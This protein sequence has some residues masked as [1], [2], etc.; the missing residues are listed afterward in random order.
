MERRDRREGAETAGK[1]VLFVSALN[2]GRK[3]T[4]AS[5][6]GGLGVFSAVSALAATLAFASPY[7]HAPAKQTVQEA[8]AK[9]A[10]CMSCHTATDRATMHQNPGVVLG[11]T[12]CHG[13]DAKVLRPQG[14][15]R[16]DS[17]Y[18]ATLRR[19]HVLPRDERAW[20]WP[21]SATPERTFTLLNR[22]SP[23]FVRAS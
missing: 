18:L 11:C 16:E 8:E 22:E 5:F 19:A 2:E 15:K 12:D 10:G 20:R 23:E 17:A 6:L 1:G 13:G 21:S 4:L 3:H 9:S 7:P 14:A